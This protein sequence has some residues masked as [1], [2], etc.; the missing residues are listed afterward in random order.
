MAC[1]VSTSFSVQDGLVQHKD[2]IETCLV[3]VTRSKG[4]IMHR[5]MFSG[6]HPF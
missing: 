5:K 1:A 4:L 6:A 2:E 3:S